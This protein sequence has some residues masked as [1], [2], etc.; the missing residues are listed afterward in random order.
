MIT[1]IFTL[2]SCR[3]DDAPKPPVETGEKLSAIEWNSGFKERYE[4][5][6]N[7]SLKKI[8]YS[9]T[10]SG[11]DAVEF[12]WTGN[13][14][15]EVN[16]NSSSYKNVYYY[17]GGKV[18]RSTN[19]TRN[20]PSIVYY[21]LEYDYRADGRVNKMRYITFG[22]NGPELKTE[23]DYNY[24]TAGELTS[25]VSRSGTTVITQQIDGY[26]NVAFNPWAFIDL[27]LL[28]NYMIFNYPVLSTM[29]GFPRKI[30]RIVK[31]GNDPE[32]VDITTTHTCEISKNQITKMVV[33]LASPTTPAINRK[34]TALFT[35][36]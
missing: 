8:I 29:N 28:E 15:T 16:E 11:E 26:T 12:S 22:A 23:T 34:R 7:N 24:N 25:T 4:Y 32:F 31:Q 3:K 5:N 1:T 19:E 2:Q 20:A 21:H 30:T 18:T 10:Q 6:T 17:N 33:E 9:S 27:T 13:L 36:K 14:V 35:Y